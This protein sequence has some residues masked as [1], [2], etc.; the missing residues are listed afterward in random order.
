MVACCNPLW[1]PGPHGLLN[2]LGDRPGGAGR[3]LPLGGGRG[4]TGA[5][6]RRCRSRCRPGSGAVATADV[7]GDATGDLGVGHGGGIFGKI[8]VGMAGVE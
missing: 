6:R 8:G 3:R 4:A 2:R 7:A 1:F 5:E